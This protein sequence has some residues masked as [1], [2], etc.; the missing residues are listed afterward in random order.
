MCFVVVDKV[1]VRVD[2]N[3]IVPISKIFDRNSNFLIVHHNIA[4]IVD[5]SLTGIL[6]MP[7]V[8]KESVSLRRMEGDLLA[9]DVQ[10]GA[11]NAGLLVPPAMNLHGLV[12]SSNVVC[13]SNFA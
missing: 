5:L 11:N 7:L 12:G 13:G 10:G 9:F 6:K 2:F 1:L 8:L 3:S 4:W